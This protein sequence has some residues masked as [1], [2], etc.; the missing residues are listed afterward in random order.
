MTA[1]TDPSLVFRSRSDQ[2]HAT[3]DGDGPRFVATGEMTGGEFGLFEIEI[4]P[5]G[6]GAL[7]HY[8]TTFTESFYVLDGRVRFT[9]GDD[10]QVATAGDFAFV[11][12]HGVHGFTNDSNEEPARMLIL[13]TPGVAREDYFREMIELHRRQEHPTASEVDAVAARHDQVNLRSH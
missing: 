6:D 9:L 11:P 7:A 1:P 8:H 3:D 2:E 4:E 5:G 12:R 13:F 10:E